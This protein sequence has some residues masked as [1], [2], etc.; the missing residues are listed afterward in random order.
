[1]AIRRKKIGRVIKRMVIF[2]TTIA[3]LFIVFLLAMGVMEYCPEPEEVL[4][5]D[6]EAP[7]FSSDTIRLLSWNIGY[8]G[9]GDDMDFFLRWG[10]EYAYDETEND[11]EFR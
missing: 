3:V 2:V 6:E 10:K 9:L 8:A 4:F 1:M 7:V 11:R 5:E